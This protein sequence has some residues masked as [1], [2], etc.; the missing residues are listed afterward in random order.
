MFALSPTNCSI[1]LHWNT[2][3]TLILNEFKP[4]ETTSISTSSLSTKA[5]HKKLLPLNKLTNNKFTKLSDKIIQL[6]NKI[7]D[8]KTLKDC[9]IIIVQK[10][11]NE[12]M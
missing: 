4:P 3:L 10:A 5:I 11:Q 8:S 6:F 2:L 7:E 9:I 1:F 12:N